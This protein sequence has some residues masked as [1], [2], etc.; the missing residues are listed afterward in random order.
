MS[1]A[2][3]AGRSFQFSFICRFAPNRYASRYQQPLFCTRCSGF[4]AWSASP[5]FTL[6]FCCAPNRQRD[7]CFKLFSTP[8]RRGGGW[9]GSPLFLV[10]AACGGADNKVVRVLT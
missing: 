9:S 3:E 8:M 5:L 2:P 1:C 4:G 10:V 6:V 7:S